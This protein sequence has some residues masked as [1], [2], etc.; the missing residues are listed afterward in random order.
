MAKKL[1][2][3]DDRG[4]FVKGTGGGPGHPD[5]VK[6]KKLKRAVLEATTAAAVKRIIKKLDSM[7]SGG[8]IRAA[9][10]Y[11]RYAVGQPKHEFDPRRYL[12]QSED[13]A[14][15]APMTLQE[16][17]QFLRGALW[18]KEQEAAAQAPVVIDAEVDDGE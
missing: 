18:A 12:P 5:M 9:E 15:V 16:E 11:L 8:D 6:I 4:R 2:K 14:Q 13:G 17:I 7:A 10:L 3:R 1:T